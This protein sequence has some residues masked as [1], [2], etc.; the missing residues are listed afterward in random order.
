M[1][2]LS[3]HQGM[4][5]MSNSLQLDPVQ[6]NELLGEMTRTVIGAL[7]PWW[8]RLMVDFGAIGRNIDLA[9]GVYDP[10]GT[11][12]LWDLPQK[13]FEMMQRLRMG[14]YR[15]DE[16]TWFSARFTIEQPSRFS[17]QYN[18]RNPP[19]FERYPSAEDFALEQKRYPRTEMFMPQWYREGLT[20]SSV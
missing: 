14:M 9:V 15:D 16:G 10:N 12:H 5:A 11:N 3:A 1:P 7:P 17:V 18:W 8:R 2:I 20:Q 13:P 6:Q 4:P 19:S